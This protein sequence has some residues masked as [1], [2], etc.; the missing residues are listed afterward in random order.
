MRIDLA[1]A[2]ADRIGHLAEVA[3]C[4]GPEAAIAVIVDADGAGCPTCDEEY[5]D[6]CSTLTGGL[7]RHD[8]ALWAVHWWTRWRSVA[9]GTA[10]TAGAGSIVDDPARPRCACC[11]AR[12]S[13]ALAAYRPAGRHR[14]RRPG[15]QCITGRGDRRACRVASP[16]TP[17]RR[18]GVRPQ[19]RRGRDGRAARVADGTNSPTPN[20]PAWRARWLTSKCETRFT[21]WQ[22]ATARATPSRCG[23]CCRAVCPRRGGLRRWCCSLSAPMPAATGRW[24]GCRWTPRCVVSPATGWRACWT[25][26]CNRVC[27]P[28]TFANWR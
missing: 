17:H 3:A 19:R 20:W 26:R 12:R 18:D 28:S 21:R 5:R 14:G 25:P 11:G 22:S 23:R 24:P 9:G 10:W 13:P 15:R 7:S 8:I 6:L 16:G 27:G 1:D 4:A 2:V